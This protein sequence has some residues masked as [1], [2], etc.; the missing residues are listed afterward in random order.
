M[1]AGSDED[2][3]WTENSEE[4]DD[5]NQELIRALLVEQLEEY[6]P[7]IFNIDFNDLSDLKR[8]G[9]GNFGQVWK[10]NYFGTKVAVKQLLDV[11]DADMHKYITREMLTLRDVRHPNVVQLMGLCKHSSGIYIVTEYIPGGHLRRL[12]KNR[13]L[14]LPW[15]L[16]IR[17]AQ[18]IMM[19]LTY[20]HSRGI[21][22]RDLK[23]Q[24]LLV[25][26][27]YRIKVCDFGFSRLVEKNE[28]MTVCG[29]DE[30]M[31]PEVRLGKMYD[32]RADV[33]SFSM[34][35]T[36]LITRNKPVERIPGKQFAFDSVS[37]R[38]TAPPDCPRPL[39][40]LTCAM[41]AFNPSE[42][43]G[44]KDGLK[45]LKQLR[46]VLED[47]DG[48]VGGSGGSGGGSQTSSQRIGYRMSQAFEPA[49]MKLALS[50]EA[51]AERDR[52][53]QQLAA[54]SSAHSVTGGGGGGGVGSTASEGMTT[55][56]RNYR[57]VTEYNATRESELTIRPGDV[58]VIPDKAG[59]GGL[60]G[61]VQAELNGR[62][63]WLPET[64]ANQLVADDSTSTATVVAQ[65][66]SDRMENFLTPSSS[67]DLSASAP[68]PEKKKGKIARFFSR[69]KD[70]KGSLLNVGL[71]LSEV[72]MDDIIIRMIEG[73]PTATH[74][75]QADTVEHS[76]LGTDAISWLVSNG[77]AKN[78]KLAVKLMK[79][80]L[81]RRVVFSRPLLKEKIDEFVEKAPYCFQAVEWRET[82]VLNADKMWSGT[83]RT[84]SEVIGSLAKDLLKLVVEFTTARPTNDLTPL[85]V[86]HQFLK[87]CL[88]SS[89]LQKISLDLSPTDMLTFWVNLRAFFVL[90]GLI[91]FGSPSSWQERT[92]FFNSLRVYVSFQRFTLQEIESILILGLSGF[93]P[94]DPRARFAATAKNS[95]VLL[96]LF[97]GHRSSPPY[98]FY[99]TKTFSDSLEEALRPWLAK[100][101]VINKPAAQLILPKHLQRLTS[102]FG[103][104]GLDVLTILT[105]YLPAQVKRFLAEMQQADARLALLYS[106]YDW[107]SSF[108][109]D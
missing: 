77:L 76:F 57:A 92:R 43:M 60:P 100:T 109:K 1:A 18:D 65:A 52:Q 33:F 14:D 56:G 2:S 7:R 17:I 102:Q 69:K 32:E 79:Y 45:V 95:M 66:P 25:D 62:V 73:I 49:A 44:F 99:T 83:T 15:S 38:R 8:I 22:H 48:A 81:D 87:I 19:A 71:N 107:S 75:Y 9:G 27:G 54:A 3:S 90:L 80:L 36:E 39:V 11:D 20:L 46:K 104:S 106:E 13:E 82:F 101:I 72:Q 23:S 42:R 98:S 58:I 94:G 4:Q 63:G 78:P 85:A 74:K 51:V 6:D 24:N 30:W 68:T 26:D 67:H 12:L 70:K 41:G 29:T 21:V 84:P 88:K 37:F 47:A 86:D 28:F 40:D 31:A 5:P 93:P 97:D 96:S 50:E 108:R 61:F 64:I 35:L 53:P 91:R 89:E 55:I 105:P 10:A 103:C 59:T 16:R 34:V